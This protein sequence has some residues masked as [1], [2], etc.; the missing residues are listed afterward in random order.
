MSLNQAIEQMQKAQ[1][2]KIQDDAKAREAGLKKQLEAQ[3][4]KIDQQED[5][6]ALKREAAEL[7][8][9]ANDKLSLAS[10]ERAKLEIEKAEQEG[11]SRKLASEKDALEAQKREMKTELEKLE[12]REKVFSASVAGLLVTSILGVVAAFRAG[13]SG[14]LGNKKLELEIIKLE[15]ELGL[16][17]GELH[18]A[19]VTNESPKFETTEPRRSPA[20]DTAADGESARA[21]RSQRIP[22]GEA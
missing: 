3:K 17:K 8:E 14:K 4:K 22:G 10:E 19:K 12:F 11:V 20:F 6:K 7:A 13:R 15:R 9:E 1:I 5:A 2:K 16:A 18:Q 21:D